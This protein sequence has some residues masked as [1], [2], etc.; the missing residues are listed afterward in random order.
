ME[1][2]PEPQDQEHYDAI[3]ESVE[4]AVRIL[5]EAAGGVEFWVLFSHGFVASFSNTLAGVLY[6]CDSCH[7]LAIRHTRPDAGWHD[8]TCVCGAKLRLA[9]DWLEYKA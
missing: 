5:R 8:V 3:A 6:L 2:K 4:R 9:A 7:R 1:V